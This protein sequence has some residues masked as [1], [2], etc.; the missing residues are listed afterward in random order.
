MFANSLL[1]CCNNSIEEE[2]WELFIR[3]VILLP[4]N[5]TLVCQLEVFLLEN[6]SI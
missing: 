6:R 2:V 4:I 5:Y 3:V 1:L